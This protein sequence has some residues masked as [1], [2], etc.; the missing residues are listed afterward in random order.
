MKLKSQAGRNVTEVTLPG[1]ISD[2]YQSKQGDCPGTWEEGDSL[3]PP[4]TPSGR[5]RKW[6]DRTQQPAGKFPSEREAAGGGGRQG[7]PR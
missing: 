1:P 5:P 7:Q 4:V 3:C 2:L 6:R